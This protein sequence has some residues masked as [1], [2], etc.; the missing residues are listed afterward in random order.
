MIFPNGI[1]SKSTVEIRDLLVRVIE[2]GY[3][4]AMF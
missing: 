1:L 4:I 2:I 3:F